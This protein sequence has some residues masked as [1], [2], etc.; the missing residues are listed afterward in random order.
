MGAVV[1]TNP[2]ADVIAQGGEDY[3]ELLQ[4]V[5]DGIKAL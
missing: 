4:K 3:T 2:A 1:I 5:L